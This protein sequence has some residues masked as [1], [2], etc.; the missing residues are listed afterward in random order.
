MDITPHMIKYCEKHFKDDDL[1]QDLYVKLLEMDEPDEWDDNWL[2]RMYTNLRIDQRRK[3][4]RRREIL[5]EFRDLVASSTTG[6]TGVAPDPADVL[7]HEEEMNQRLE[8]LSDMQ[9]N[10]LNELYFEGLTP[11]ELAEKEGVAR[12]AIDQRVHNIKKALKGEI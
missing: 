10:T 8:E 7:E 11:E 3:E 4:M 5:T 2:T 9:L 12:N 6:H 1:R